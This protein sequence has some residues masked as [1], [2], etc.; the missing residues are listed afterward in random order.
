[1]MVSGFP[2]YDIQNIIIQPTHQT[3]DYHAPHQNDSFKIHH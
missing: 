2:D 1:M 3:W